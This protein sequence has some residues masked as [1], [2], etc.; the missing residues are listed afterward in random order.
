[1]FFAE[2]HRFIPFRCSLATLFSV[3]ALFFSSYFFFGGEGLVS[4]LFHSSLTFF[5]LVC[6]DGDVIAVWKFAPSLSFLSLLSS[7][8]QANLLTSLG[9][10]GL[11]VLEFWDD[12]KRNSF[13]N[14]INTLEGSW[15]YIVQDLGRRAN[16]SSSCCSDE[17]PYSLNLIWDCAFKVPPGA[18][19][20]SCKTHER[21]LTLRLLLVRTRNLQHTKKVQQWK[22]PPSTSK[23]TP[24]TQ[25]AKAHF[26]HSVFLRLS[27]DGDTSYPRWVFF[28]FMCFFFASATVCALFVLVIELSMASPLWNAVQFAA[29][30]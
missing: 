6:C 29:S 26:P 11:D 3:P 30:L 17:T 12:R 18:S 28:A 23:E 2:P 24:Q 8:R 13:K 27:R 4:V 22:Y 25:V 1:M 10:F 19:L 16:I 7:C 14:A 20:N 15:R 9:S 21:Q 5:F